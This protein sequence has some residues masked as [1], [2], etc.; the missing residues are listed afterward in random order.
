MPI[1]ELGVQKIEDVHERAIKLWIHAT[2]KDENVD[3]ADGIFFVIT[4]N[5]WPS[6]VPKVDNAIDLCSV[7]NG[8]FGLPP[9]S[10]E[11]EKALNLRALALFHNYRSGRSPIQFFT[12]LVWANRVAYVVAAISLLV[13][14]LSWWVVAL[15]AAVW[16]CFGAARTAVRMRREQRRPEWEF[17]AIAAMH[18]VALLALYVVSVVHLLG[19]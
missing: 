8:A 13:S 4:G 11:D 16:S 1:A 9:L 17:P 15:G 3:P 14:G 18:L 6:E 2:A 5:S 7:L 12:S 19:F 10:E